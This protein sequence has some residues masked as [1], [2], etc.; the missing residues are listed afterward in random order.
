G[1]SSETMSFYDKDWSSFVTLASPGKMRREKG[2]P[3]GSPLYRAIPRDESVI[4]PMLKH[5]SIMGLIPK[6]EFYYKT[7]Q[8]EKDGVTYAGLR[9][10]QLQMRKRLLP[11]TPYYYTVLAL[12]ETRKYLPFAPIVEGIAYANPPDKPKELNIVYL[13]DQEVLNFE[14]EEPKFDVNYSIYAVEN[15]T[16]YDSWY[17][18]YKAWVEKYYEIDKNIDYSAELHQAYEELGILPGIKIYEDYALPFASLSVEELDDLEKPITEYHFVLS[19]TNEAGLGSFTAAYDIS[20]ENIIASSDLV[21]MDNV[22][23]RNKA[24]TKGD[25]LELL[26]GMP[27]ATISSV[28]YLNPEQTH[29][30]LSYEYSVNPDMHIKNIYFEFRDGSGNPI[31]SKSGK[32]IV[33]KAFY[34]DKI[35][36]VKL[37]TKYDNLNVK[38]SFNVKGQ[39]IDKGYFLTQDLEFDEV[40]MSL[41]PKKLYYLEKE[42]AISDYSFYLLRKGRAGNRFSVAR[43][44]PY[45]DREISDMIPYETQVVKG[46]PTYDKASRRLLVDPS[47]DVCY[48]PSSKS[49]LRTSIFPV[50]EA[51]NEEN[52]FLREINNVKSQRTRA[53]M[54]KK[55][56]ENERRTFTYALVLSNGKGRFTSK[57]VVLGG[58]DGYSWVEGVH[59]EGMTGYF[60]KP[61]PGWF[62][63]SKLATLITSIIFGVLVQVYVLLAKKGKNLFIR[64]IAGIE[65]IDNAIGRATE[66][67]RPI[68]FCPGLSGIND[69][70]TLAGLAI[71]G[72]VAKKAAE[73]DTKILVPNR[74]YIVMPIATEIVR[75]AH[76]EAGRPDSFDKNNIFF[77]SE[78]QFAYVAGV[79][80]IMIREKTATNFYMGMFYAESLIMTETGNSTGAIQIAGTDAV[81][82]IPFFITT[83]DYTLMGEELYAAAAYMAR[84]PLQLGTLKAQDGTKLLILIFLILGTLL[85]SIQVT[86]IIYMFP[87][88]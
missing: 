79:N 88:K 28:N 86:N 32:P 82:Q 60:L 5:Y 68:L 29:L 78:Q 14:W 30:L 22:L 18:N 36:K 71:L 9:S 47:I 84:Q 77:I 19:F 7:K 74:D 65:E 17:E 4:G 46:I 2:Q 55:L 61:A 67:G 75:E 24:S 8:I 50:T 51:G 57:T 59:A 39:A 13:E 25:Y 11:E 6:N 23:L 33:V 85:S 87:D 72:R 76:Y 31:K 81:T 49:T 37:P 3:K 54:I 27:F 62:E 69:V 26:W 64:P 58:S 15:V 56:R 38:I 12:T 45:F 63:W 10:T 83:C 41:R 70:A 35:I 66:M 44:A 16:E 73:Y 1:I 20:E 42:V 43:T 80:G 53:N 34:L 40:I 21:T 52:I 48:D